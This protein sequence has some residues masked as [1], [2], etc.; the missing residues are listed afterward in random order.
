MAKMKEFVNKL[1]ASLDTVTPGFSGRKLTALY[2]VIMAAY[3]THKL[4]PTA[5]LYALYAW[6]SLAL[7]CLGII[8][9]EQII[10][11]KNGNKDEPSTPNQP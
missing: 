3:V 10:K 5:L 7:L 8:T 1:I 6:Q 4:P 2:S 11:I 9:A